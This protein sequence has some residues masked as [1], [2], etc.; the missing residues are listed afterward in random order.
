MTVEMPIGWGAGE[1]MAELIDWNDYRKCSQICRAK[2]G[3]PCFS[4]NGT[5]VNGQTDGVRTPLAVPHKARKR[6]KRR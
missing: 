4:L 5:V 1:K 3:E 6:R 2:I